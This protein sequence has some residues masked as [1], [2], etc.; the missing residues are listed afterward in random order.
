MGA[1]TADATKGEKDKKVYRKKCYEWLLAVDHMLST[2]I[3]HCIRALGAPQLP[4]SRPLQQYPCL[5]LVMDLGVEGWGA[6]WFL[7]LSLN[8]NC[9]IVWGPLPQALG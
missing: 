6:A 9:I 4:A 1:D 3:G 5:T 2:L 8:I 7:N